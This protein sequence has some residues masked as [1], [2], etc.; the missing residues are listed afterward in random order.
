MYTFYF[1]VVVKTSVEQ[2]N[3]MSNLKFDLQENIASLIIS[4]NQE[5]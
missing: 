1:Y 4:S 2:K 3:K 5:S